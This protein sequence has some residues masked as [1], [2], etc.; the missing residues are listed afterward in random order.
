[1]A[2]W[3]MGG[4]LVFIMLLPMLKSLAAS[5]VPVSRCGNRQTNM[6]LNRQPLA[7]IEGGGP[8][9]YGAGISAGSGS[10]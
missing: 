9:T 5:F 7:P 2:L 8:G 3:A 6:A 1:M 4:H 10:T